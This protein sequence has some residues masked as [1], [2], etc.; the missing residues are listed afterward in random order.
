MALDTR[1]KR[2]SAIGIGL[3]LRL[4]LPSPDGAVGG[5][6]RQQVAYSYAGISAAELAVLN[7]C[8]AETR[9]LRPARTTYSLRPVRT[10][11]AH[12]VHEE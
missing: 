3:A 10:T 6:D 5:P 9:S 11:T 7:L 8:R 12:C 2:A 1:N 4:V